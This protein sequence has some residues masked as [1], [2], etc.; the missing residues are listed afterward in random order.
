MLAARV[1]AHEANL[2]QSWQAMTS[3]CISVVVPTYNRIDRIR[4]VL[5]ALERQTYPRD[6]FEVIVISDGSTDGTDDYLR[7][8]ASGRVRPIFQPNRGPAAARNT[9]IRAAAGQLIVF[10][11]DDVVPELG[12]LTAHADIHRA[13]GRQVAV[14]GPLLTPTDVELAPWVAWEQ[15]MLEKQYNAMADGRWQPT[16]RQFYTGNASI[17][18]DVLID[19]GGFDEKFRRAEDVELAYRLAGRGIGF[20]FSMAPAGY[21]YAERSFASWMATAQA[22]GR[23]DAIFGRDRG[24]DWLISVVRE[25]FGYRKRSLRML[26]TACLKSPALASTCVAGMRGVVTAAGLIGFRSMESAGY[27]AIFGVE[28]YRGF[29]HELG[30]P[31][32]CDAARLASLRNG[33]GR[34]TR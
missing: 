31:V 14:I 19:A 8:V 21:H 33:H 26:I 3:L 11:D 24:Q 10:V 16:A 5:A 34:S 32:Y 6:H 12:L 25:E 2:G 1:S 7:S 15:A 29:F 28:Y 23:N 20:I 30:E 18:R 27:S 13:A 17:G 9:G 4:R 22:Y